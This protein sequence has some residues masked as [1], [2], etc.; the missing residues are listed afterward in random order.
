MGMGPLCCPVLSAHVCN[1]GVLWPNAWMDQD[2]TWYAGKPRLVGPGHIVLDGELG[3]H[4]PSLKGTQQQPPISAHICCGQMADGLRCQCH[5]VYGGRLGLGP[6][7]FVLDGDPAPHSPKGRA[8]PPPQ[9]LAHVHLRPNGCMDQDDTW[10]GGEP[11]YRPHCAR[12]GVGH[13]AP[14]PIKGG[15]ARSIFGP[16]LLQPNGCNASRCHFVLR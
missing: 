15:G 7:N 13:P 6:G 16:C 11:W 4:L 8:V 5:S 10:H 12:W 2:E 1:V 3:I 9:F 14:F